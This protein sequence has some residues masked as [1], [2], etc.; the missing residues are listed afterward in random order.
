MSLFKSFG[1]AAVPEIKPFTVPENATVET[2]VEMYRALLETAQTV[3]DARIDPRAWICQAT[4]IRHDLLV[5]FYFSHV[6]DVQCDLLRAERFK[7]LDP[8][9]TPEELEAQE[10]ARLADLR[11]AREKAS[12]D[13]KARWAAE[14]EANRGWFSRL[15]GK[16]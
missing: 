7:A 2:L 15:F 1:D 12:A 5:E 3:K 6:V 11:A 4:N 13:L 16:K 14:R 8:T 9:P 10:Q